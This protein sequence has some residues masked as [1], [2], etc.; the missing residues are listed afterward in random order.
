[1]PQQKT[2][3]DSARKPSS[4]RAKGK[5]APRATQRDKARR[6]EPVADGYDAESGPLETGFASEDISLDRSAILDDGLSVTPEDLGRHALLAAAQQESIDFDD[7]AT[8]GRL[9]DAVDEPGSARAGRL[10][11]V[12]LTD[13]V[14]R[15]GSLFDEPLE[16][17]NLRTPRSKTNEVDASHERDLR[18]RRAGELA[19]PERRSSNRRG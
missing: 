18:A 12:D 19:T 7:S 9:A 14:A 10:P 3:V 5:T 16:D 8:R 15:E 17:G 13:D 6:A 11:D 4:S 1:M 2:P